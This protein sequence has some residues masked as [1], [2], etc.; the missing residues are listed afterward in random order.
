MDKGLQKR[1]DRLFNLYGMYGE[2]GYIG[3]RVSQI[4]HALQCARLAENDGFNEYVILGSFLHDVGHL[5][6]EE[7]Q[8][9]DG[10]DSFQQM[11]RDNVSYGIGNHEIIGANFLR[12]LNLPEIISNFVEN[13]VSAKRYLVYKVKFLSFFYYL[14]FTLFYFYAVYLRIKP[15]MIV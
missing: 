9:V 2:E 6:G 3:E 11:I 10:A 15:T 4:E 12:E 8:A 14:D 13:H 5:L 1:L 7:K